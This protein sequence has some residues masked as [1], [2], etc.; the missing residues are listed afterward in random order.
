MYSGLGTFVGFAKKMVGTFENLVPDL[1][2]QKVI[3]RLAIR[4][5]IC[6]TIPFNTDIYLSFDPKELA[7][8]LLLQHIRIFY[9]ATQYASLIH[10]MSS[11]ILEP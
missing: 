10:N 9:H 11:N 1:A 3:I 2:I 6:G 4:R 5:G 7:S 8:H